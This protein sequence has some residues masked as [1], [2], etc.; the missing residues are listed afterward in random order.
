V[1][2]KRFDA[3]ASRA[4]MARATGRRHLDVLERALA[5]HEAGSAGTRSAAE[6]RFLS[7]VTRA[8]LPEPRVNT[9]IEVDFHWPDLGLCVEVDGPGHDRPRTRRDDAIRDRALTATGRTVLR[10]DADTPHDEVVS[11][12]RGAL[13]APTE[14]PPHEPEPLEP[15]QPG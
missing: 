11:A 2:R 13:P 6:D 14:P 5:A 4:A 8:G 3:A 7:A 9:P 12:L 15:P 1:Y 10:L